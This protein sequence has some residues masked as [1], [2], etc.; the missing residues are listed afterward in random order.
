M[1][2]QIWAS[3]Q[4]TDAFTLSQALL[5]A[6]ASVNSDVVLSQGHGTVLV[7]ARSNL[8]GT[9][10]I[11]HRIT[12]GGAEIQTDIEASGADP[13]SGEQVVYM[14]ANV[15]GPF[16]R[17]RFTNDGVATQT[18]F[19]I[20][21]YLLPSGGGGAGGGGGGG[22]GAADV[23]NADADADFAA[24][25]FGMLTNSRLA[26]LDNGSGDWA[27]WRGDILSNYSAAGRAAASVSGAW[28]NAVT[29]GIDTTG[30]NVSRPVEARAT[31]GEPA[32]TL[33]SLS[34]M[35]L[36]HGMN[37]AST[38]WNRIYAFAASGSADE[39]GARWLAVRSA[40]TGL[41]SSA[42]LGSRNTPVEARNFDVAQADVDASLIGL[43]TNTRVASYNTV[44][45]AWER[46]HGAFWSAAGGGTVSPA[47]VHAMSVN[48]MTL[49]VDNTGAA[50]VRAVEARAAS[51]TYTDALIGLLV[52]NRPY[53][54]DPN[55]GTWGLGLGV[56]INTARTIFAAA[57]ADA[58]ESGY[59]AVD[60]GRRFFITHQTVGTEITAQATFVATTPT[61][62]IYNSAGNTSTLI[63]RTIRLT[64]ASVTANA[65]KVAVMID[66]DDRFSAGGTAVVPQNSNE[67]SATAYPGTAA[68]FNPTAT[69]ADADERVLWN[70]RIPAG[71]DQG[72]TLQWRDGVQISGV[73]SILVYIY[74]DAGL[75][76]PSL[77][78][79]IELEAFPP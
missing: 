65:V 47:S 32:T 8:A 26:Y 33:T 57:T 63:L 31:S 64:I 5:A 34:S 55:A 78:F 43:T 24:A 38:A 77:E 72:I 6:G 76:A 45:G 49:G 19:Q 50:V 39:S 73:G 29:N 42:A 27:R 66:P 10:R 60:L 25:L 4:R 75:V 1:S 36:V 22:G 21:A 15:I 62:L 28:V 53:Y 18:D 79:D 12:A 40:V 46:T 41:D 67:A 58:R 48:A 16:M 9:V 44:A 71:I 30:A 7:I 37:A 23:R 17:V 68:R 3:R 59:F 70:D 56:P 11:F 2:S 74:D 13:I 51:A 61:I 52:Q 54:R 14:V 69:A 20:S 35:A